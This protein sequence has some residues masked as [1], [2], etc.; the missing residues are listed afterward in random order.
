M[1]VVRVARQVKH[2]W[3]VANKRAHRRL[4][5]GK[6]T[7][8]TAVTPAL[9]EIRPYRYDAQRYAGHNRGK[10]GHELAFLHMDPP[11]DTSPSELPRRVFV[12]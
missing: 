7:A 8:L 6:W 1:D 5:E 2:A 9:S 3:F 10:E 4:R 12:V 11:A